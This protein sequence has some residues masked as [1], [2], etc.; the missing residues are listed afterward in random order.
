VFPALCLALA[1]VLYSE[2]IPVFTEAQRSLWSLQPVKKPAVPAVKERQWVKNPIDAFVL[3]K[4]EEKQLQPNKP[5]DRL[6]LLRRITID[7]TGLPPRQE[8]IESFLNDRAPNAYEKVVDRLLASPAYGERWGRHWLDVARYADSDG[9]KADA[10]R[11]HIW[12]YRDY[13]IKAFNEDKPFDRFVREQIAGDELYPNNPEAMIA[14]GFN[15]HWI[16]E[17]NAAGLITRRQE[18]IDEMTSVTASAI[19]RHRKEKGEFKSIDDLKKVPG[20]DVLKV[21]AQRDRLEF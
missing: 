2:E 21:D 7:M 6:T 20:I 1:G 17:T 13:V 10:T 14:M 12:R 9:F 3:A 4:L 5:A 11:P 16:D 15:R 18:T 19:V 8:E